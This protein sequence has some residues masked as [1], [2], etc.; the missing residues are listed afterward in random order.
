MSQSK[1]MYTAKTFYI[2]RIY[3]PHADIHSIMEQLRGKFPNAC[4]DYL[5]GFGT[6]LHVNIPL[7]TGAKFV[8]VHWR[9][10]KAQLPFKNFSPGSTVSVTINQHAVLVG[11]SKA[12][13]EQ[14]ITTQLSDGCDEFRISTLE[15]LEQKDVEVVVPGFQWFDEAASSTTS[16]KESDDV[17]EK[18]LEEQAALLHNQKEAL[19]SQTKMLRI[20]EERHAMMREDFRSN[21][22]RVE[23]D[24]AKMND[25]FKALRREKKKLAATCRKMEAKVDDTKR[26]R[27]AEDAVAEAQVELGKAEATASQ[28]RC[29]LVEVQAK[30]LKMGVACTDGLQRE[31]SWEQKLKSIQEQFRKKR[32][33][34]LSRIEHL[35]KETGALQKDLKRA[36]KDRNTAEKELVTLK[37]AKETREERVLQLE[38]ENET[39]SDVCEGLR[40]LVGISEQYKGSNQ[41]IIDRSVVLINNVLQEIY[42][43][44]PDKVSMEELRQKAAM[45]YH[46]RPK[47]SALTIAL[48][49]SCYTTVVL[50]YREKKEEV[51]RVTQR[52]EKLSE[53]VRVLRLRIKDYIIHPRSKYNMSPGS[54]CRASLKKFDFPCE[55]TV[56]LSAMIQEYAADCSKDSFL[57]TTQNLYQLDTLYLTGLI[58]DKAA[59]LQGVVRLQRWS[60]TTMQ[61]VRLRRDASSF[62]RCKAAIRIQRWAR[63]IRMKRLADMLD[64]GKGTLADTNVRTESLKHMLERCPWK[65]EDDDARTIL[66]GRTLAYASEKNSHGEYFGRVPNH[67]LYE[68]IMEQVADELMMS[69]PI[70]MGPVRLRTLMR[71][72]ERFNDTKM[73]PE[74]DA[75]KQFCENRETGGLNDLKQYLQKGFDDAVRDFITKVYPKHPKDWKEH[76][77]CGIY[78][79]RG[80]VDDLKKFLF[81][82]YH[83]HTSVF[84]TVAEVAQNFGLGCSD[85]EDLVRRWTTLHGYAI[86]ELKG[87]DIQIRVKGEPDSPVNVMVV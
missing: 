36:Q 51:E 8:P 30:L 4:V 31:K 53:T 1:M 17:L 46:L 39:I 41:Q 10:Y 40:H 84:L 55:E 7:D 44:S 52:A 58:S 21:C 81:D 33:S 34:R 73:F 67:I 76:L 6:Q 65:Q 66:R 70:T 79:P 13:K 72:Q 62:F 80:N 60:R 9:W 35:E 11:F 68:Q 43:L 28:L 37:S 45:Y 77:L 83:Q 23:E 57:T 47:S 14:Y 63:W 82:R 86:Q 75:L 71:E 74:F 56:S 78:I 20:Q 61:R 38:K 64:S 69:T 49:K 22:V 18:K 15:R 5:Q 27:Y 19:C 32:K 85:A 3:D 2:L 29:E 24:S 12:P 54:S 16:E 59:Y 26:L 87:K 48:L 42:H 25:R 50:H